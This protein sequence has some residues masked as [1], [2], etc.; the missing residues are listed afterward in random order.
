MYCAYRY[1]CRITRRGSYVFFCLG[2]APEVQKGR[3]YGKR[4]SGWED[5]EMD[6]A[7]TG[8]PEKRTGADA[9]RRGCEVQDF[10]E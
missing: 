10:P 9:L 1:E 8:V 2:L 4:D 6:L 7:G 3:G 5:G